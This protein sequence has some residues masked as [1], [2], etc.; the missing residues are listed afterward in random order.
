MKRTHFQV[1]ILAGLVATFALLPQA[2]ADLVYEDGTAAQA[3]RVDDRSL[4]RQ[5]LGASEK[6]QT[7]LQQQPAQT[8]VIQQTNLQQPL[9]PAQVQVGTAQLAQDTAPAPATDEVQNLSKSELIRRERLR[10]EMKNEDVLQERLEELRLRDEQ[11]RTQEILGGAPQAAQQDAPGNV[12]LPAPIY[13][14]AAG[15]SGTT[16][17]GAVAAQQQPAPV[18][19]KVGQAAAVSAADVKTSNGGVLVA[20]ADSSGGVSTATISSSADSSDKDKSGITVSPRFGLSNMSDQGDF[21][22]SSKFSAGVAASIAASDNLSFEVG[23]T[24]SEYGVDVGGPLAQQ[25]QSMTGSNM[26]PMTMNQNVIDAGLKLYLLGPDSRFRPFVGVGGGYEMSYINY[27]S[28]ILNFLNHY[29]PN[30]GYGNDY[31]LNAF[32]GEISTGFDVKVARNI[33]VGVLFK[34]Y[35]VLS[36][37][38][39]NNI[40][41]NPGYY[42][43]AY[44]PMAAGVATSDKQYVGDSLAN[45]SF[46]SVLGGV[47]FTF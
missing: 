41:N 4:T 36:S 30:S 26:D 35:R 14:G 42:G 40:F 38:E 45:A 7:A 44:G 25:I 15:A 5:A 23:Y 16:A 17:A 2:K 10:E 29:A 47:N 28:D 19:E 39:D 32:L 43:N 12:N 9:A 3:A 11:R 27:N 1:A 20:S 24:Y 18:T 34:Y 8:Q 31:N 13:T 46:Y 21:Q 22:V 6:A 33:S 37:S